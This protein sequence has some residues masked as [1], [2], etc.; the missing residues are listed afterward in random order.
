MSA[1]EE[2]AGACERA[3]GPDRELDADIH[4]A[5]LVPADARR[6]DRLGGCVGYVASDGLYRSARD[7]LRYTASIDAAM[8][9]LDQYGVLMHLSDIGADGL[10]YARVGR[11]DLF[12]EPN[13]FTG[14][15]SG[16]AKDATPTSGLAL[17]LCAAALRARGAE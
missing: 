15:S 10:P 5:V 1:L 4:I 12:E 11:P 9:L 3:M 2:M 8:T 6:V 13:I 17:A 16:I 7:A 14:I